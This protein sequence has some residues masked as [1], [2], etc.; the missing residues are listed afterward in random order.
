M[1]Q[2]GK[3]A[4]RRLAAATI[5]SILASPA[6]VPAWA[7]STGA[8]LGVRVVVVAPCGAGG[9]CEGTGSSAS[10]AAPPGDPSAAPPSPAPLVV[11]EER[12]GGRDY[13]TVI[14]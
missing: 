5:L 9:P 6:A 11:R 13:R 2:S 14:Y 3:S 4:F 7:G 10:L 1:S 12:V 8:T